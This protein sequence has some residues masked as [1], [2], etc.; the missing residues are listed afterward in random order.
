MTREPKHQHANLQGLNQKTAS[1]DGKHSSL[2]REGSDVKGSHKSAHKWD[3]R[4]N[5]GE[6][7]VEPGQ[8]GPGPTGLAVFGPVRA[9]L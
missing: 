4:S 2:N 3:A 8:K 6:A 7:G 1:L 5:R 9:P